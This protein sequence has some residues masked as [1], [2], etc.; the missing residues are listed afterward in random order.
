MKLRWPGVAELSLG[1]QKTDYEK[2]TLIPGGR[3]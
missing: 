2:N 3:R 1:L